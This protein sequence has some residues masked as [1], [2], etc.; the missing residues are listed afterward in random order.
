MLGIL[1]AE[2]AGLKVM[3]YRKADDKSFFLVIVNFFITGERE[4]SGFWVI[5]V[6]QSTY[7]SCFFAKVSFLLVLTAPFSREPK[8]INK[9]G[10]I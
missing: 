10:L 2:L 3:L 9:V 8:V 1:I 4:K 5:F 6:S 7:P